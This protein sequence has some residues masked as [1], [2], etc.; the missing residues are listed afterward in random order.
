MNK[1]GDN[2][3]FKDTSDADSTISVKF[4]IF[5]KVSSKLG[6]HVGVRRKPT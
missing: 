2:A 6:N 5:E 4:I 3:D 1:D